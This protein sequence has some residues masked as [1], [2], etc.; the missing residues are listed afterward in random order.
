MTS[1]HVGPYTLGKSLW[2]ES[3][4]KVTKPVIFLKVNLSLEIAFWIILNVVLIIVHSCH[5][6]E[7][8][9]NL[10]VKGLHVQGWQVSRSVK[11]QLL[12]FKN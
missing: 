12:Q 5:P 9:H 4:L 11:Q 1:Q 2:N 6:S 8:E 7:E 10:D 3:I